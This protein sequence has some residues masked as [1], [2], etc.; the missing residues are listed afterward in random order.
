MC[1]GKPERI[2]GV[3]SRDREC[4]G[5]RVFSHQYTIAGQIL[6]VPCLLDFSRTFSPASRL[7]IGRP[8]RISARLCFLWQNVCFSSNA[9]ASFSNDF[10]KF[11]V[12]LIVKLSE[13]VWVWGDRRDLLENGHRTFE[14]LIDFDWVSPRLEGSRVCQAKKTMRIFFT[15]PVV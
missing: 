12:Q 7:F 10:S 3:A 1:L 6:C 5:M 11:V 13:E 8:D 14:W 4:D 2:Q 15:P 9:N